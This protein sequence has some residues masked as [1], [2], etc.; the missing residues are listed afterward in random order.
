MSITSAHLNRTSDLSV[1][2]LDLLSGPSCP[3]CDLRWDEVTL[4]R[5][6][7][8]KV[9]LAKDARDLRNRLVALAEP[10]RAHVRTVRDA[11]EQV[12]RIPEAE[13]VGTGFAQWSLVLQ[14]V[15]D[16]LASPEAILGTDLLTVESLEPSSEA[17]AAIAALTAVVEGRPDVDVSADARDFLVVAQERFADLQAAKRSEREASDLSNRVLLVYGAYRRASERLLRELYQSIEADFVAYY[18]ALNPDDEGAFQAQ[19]QPDEASL[20]LTVDFYGKG[21]FPPGALH[22]EGHQDSMGL[23]LY[24]ALLKRLLGA[25]FLL[26]VLDDVVMS[27]DAEHRRRIGDLFVREFGETQFVITTHDRVWATQMQKQGLLESRNV[28]SLSGWSVETGPVVDTEGNVWA[29]I[30]ADLKRND[31]AVAA[32]RLRRHAEFAC[33]ELAERFVAQVPFRFDGNYE[34]GEL[35]PQVLKRYGDLLTKAEKAAQKWKHAEDVEALGRLRESLDLRRKRIDYEQW[36]VN[37]SVHYN[38]WANLTALEFESVVSAF[39]DLFQEFCCRDCGGWLG[40]STRV[41]PQDLR[42]PCGRARWN[43][44]AG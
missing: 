40:L 33:R 8:E 44:A 32:S 20:D 36:S 17:A 25:G 3:L 10:L 37:P 41:N 22:S 6:L 27:V 18:R 4:R 29:L 15:A 1:L 42:C 34:L 43:L 12:R 11:W 13:K 23:C 5:H 26:A 28:V 7:E 9:R 35:L 21:M 38:E 2:G 30:D 31:V 24:L 19:L 14:Q 39:R 16:H